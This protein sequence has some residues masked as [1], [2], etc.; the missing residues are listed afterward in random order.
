MIRG[1]WLITWF[2]T[3]YR[4]CNRRRPTARL[5]A[6]WNRI[7]VDFITDE[8]LE[9]TGILMRY[10]ALTFNM[11]EN[12]KT[13]LNFD[14]TYFSFVTI[15]SSF[16]DHLIFSNVIV[17]VHVVTGILFQHLNVRLVGW[18]SKDSAIPWLE[19]ERACE[20]QGS[21]LTS[22]MDITEMTLLHYLLTTDWLTNNT[23]TYIGIK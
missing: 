21:H 23:R 10:Q 16:C 8:I 3:S 18:I 6:S 12:L 4:F 5:L 13:L 20:S 1:W 15:Q 22:I 9:K 7:E 2:I 19:A 11:D 17:M 14:C